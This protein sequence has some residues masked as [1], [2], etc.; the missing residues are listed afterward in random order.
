MPKSDPRPFGPDAGQPM[1]AEHVFKKIIWRNTVALSDTMEQATTWSITGIAAMA[2]LI[3]SNLDSVAKLVSN[4]GLRW[5][6]ILFTASI[7]AGAVGKQFGM[8]ITKGLDLINRTEE[9]LSTN[10]GKRLMEEMTIP[11]DQLMDEIAAPFYW[12]LSALMR[13]SGRA[14]LTDYLSGDR[15]LV[16]MFCALLIFIYLHGIFAAAGLM[17]IACSIY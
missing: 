14:G 2:A 12:P 3:I 1:K 9:L 16:R 7:I 13:K 17:V 8:A 6:L 4:D 15:N 10:E 5:S 11:P